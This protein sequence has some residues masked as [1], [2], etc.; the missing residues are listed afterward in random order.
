MK[1]SDMIYA[2]AGVD[3]EVLIRVFVLGVSEVGL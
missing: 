3:V 1:H 2:Q